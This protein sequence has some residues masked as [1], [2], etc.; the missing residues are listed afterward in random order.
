MGNLDQAQTHF[1]DALAFSRKGGYRPELAWTCYDYAAMLIEAG[2]RA[3]PGIRQTSAHPASVRGSALTDAREKAVSLLD[4]AQVISSELGMRPLKERVSA[5]V[6]SVKA[7]PPKRRQYPQGLTKRE[8]EVLQLVASGMSNTA[9][10]EKLV[11]S[12]RTVERHISNIYSKTNAH[13]RA[14]AT[15][16]AFTHGLI[17]FN[18]AT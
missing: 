18:R 12:V 2:P 10:A 4:E 5:L 15:A 9:I 8:V 11:L 7:L 14:E 17:P 13:G 3:R 6:E 16:F 1:E